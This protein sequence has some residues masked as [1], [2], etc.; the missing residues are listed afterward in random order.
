MVAAF[1]RP[2]TPTHTHPHTHRDTHTLISK[3]IYGT[4][5]LLRG[6]KYLIGLRLNSYLTHSVKYLNDENSYLHFF[7]SETS[8]FM[9]NVWAMFAVVFLAIY[10]AN[11]AAFMITREEFHEF[12][13]LDDSRVGNLI[14]SQ[15][16]CA[17]WLA[18]NTNNIPVLLTDCNVLVLFLPVIETLQP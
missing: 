8:R 13:G 2:H 10:T 3:F 1:F 6:M 7:L 16:H 11:L 4:C 18:H 17:L 9:T 15:M 12:S 5:K 14:F